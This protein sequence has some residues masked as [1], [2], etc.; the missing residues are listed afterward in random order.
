MTREEVK[1]LIEL[2]QAY[3]DGKKI[4]YETLEGY[5]EEVP[6]VNMIIVHNPNRFRII[7]N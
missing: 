6:T 3:I 4:E 5:W 1:R 2:L 7:S